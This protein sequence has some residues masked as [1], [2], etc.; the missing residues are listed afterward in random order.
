[1]VG[2]VVMVWVWVGVVMVVGEV[3]VFWMEVVMV[4]S[5]D[6][7]VWVMSTVGGVAM[8]AVWAVTAWLTNLEHWVTFLVTG[9]LE[10]TNND[11]FVFVTVLVMVIFGVC[12]TATD[13]SSFGPDELGEDSL[14]V[15][16]S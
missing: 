7:E 10:L 9:V 12:V 13:V 16:L 1:M 14:L 6:A 11:L 2:A 3:E 8:E 15:V 5:V 4:S